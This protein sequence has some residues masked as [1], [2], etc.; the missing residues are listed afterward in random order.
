MWAFMPTD[1]RYVVKKEKIYTLKRKMKVIR[2]VKMI[3]KN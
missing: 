2:L 1:N 3:I